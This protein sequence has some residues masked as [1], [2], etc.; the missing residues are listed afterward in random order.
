MKYEKPEIVSIS[1]AIEAIQASLI[2]GHV[3]SDDD[4]HGTGGSSLTNCA[5]IADE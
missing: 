5:Y 1:P 3:E 2:K 4:C